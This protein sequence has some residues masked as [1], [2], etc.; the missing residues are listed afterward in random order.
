MLEDGKQGIVVVTGDDFVSRAVTILL[1]GA[2]YRRAFPVPVSTLFEPD[3]LDTVDLLLVLLPMP[4]LSA[5]QYDELIEVLPGMAATT[6]TRI[7]ELTVR[8][9]FE[10]MERRVREVLT[11]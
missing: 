6:G 7:L 10:D 1:R 9:R 11:T 8:Q 3:V 4:H 5:E 2:G